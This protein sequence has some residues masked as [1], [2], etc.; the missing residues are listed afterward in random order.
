MA[1]QNTLS[2]PRLPTRRSQ[3][4]GA[5]GHVMHY[6]LCRLRRS[7]REAC[8]VSCQG[9]FEPLTGERRRNPQLRAS[10]SGAPRIHIS[11]VSGSNKVRDSL[12]VDSDG[13][14]A[15]SHND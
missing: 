1:G 15:H 14:V 7:N 4:L 2:H 9:R 5:G 10:L 12:H 6:Q 11:I 3:H 13:D 8:A